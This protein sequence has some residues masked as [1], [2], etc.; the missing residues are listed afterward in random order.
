MLTDD[1]VKDVIKAI[2]E[3]RLAPG[4]KTH[5]Q[6]VKHLKDIKAQKNLTI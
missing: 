5:L 6:H 4:L 3:K 2:A 1:E